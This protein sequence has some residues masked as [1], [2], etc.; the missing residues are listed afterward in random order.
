MSFDVQDI[1]KGEKPA[2]DFNALVAVCVVQNGKGKYGENGGQ[3]EPECILG[4]A[5]HGHDLRGGK[6][7]CRAMSSGR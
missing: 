7:S 2:A 4:V 3:T 5:Q 1:S 6:L